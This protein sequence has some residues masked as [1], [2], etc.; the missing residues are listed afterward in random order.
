MASEKA[1]LM[2]SPMPKMPFSGCGVPKGWGRRVS[3]MPE[4]MGDEAVR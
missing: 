2:L 3:L 1:M 4:R